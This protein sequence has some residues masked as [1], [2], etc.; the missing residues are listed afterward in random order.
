M[1]VMS[2]SITSLLSTKRLKRLL[3]ALVLE[4]AMKHKCNGS[5]FLVRCH[6]WLLQAIAETADTPQTL[7]SAA[8][9]LQNSLRQSCSIHAETCLAQMQQ[10][11]VAFQTSYMN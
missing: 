4:A 8:C 2:R 9:M 3:D 11:T 6:A 1:I 10:G 5:A 7:A